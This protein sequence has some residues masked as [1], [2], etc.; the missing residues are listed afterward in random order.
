MVSPRPVTQ[1]QI[2]LQDCPITIPTQDLWWSSDSTDAPSAIPGP[3]VPHDASETNPVSGSVV[4][5][6]QDG[7]TCQMM[8]QQLQ[9]LIDSAVQ[10]SLAAGF[11][12]PSGSGSERLVASASP[13]RENPEDYCSAGAPASPTGSHRSHPS[14]LADMNSGEQGLSDQPAFTGLFPQ[15][16]F[17]SLLF[18]VVNI[19]Q[20]TSE[21]SPP[22]ST[23]APGSLD[24][25]FAEPAKPVM[26]IPTPPLFL[27]V[28][29]K[30]WVS[31]G[32][33]P[34]PSSNDR[35]N[36]TVAADSSSGSVC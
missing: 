33:A 30:Q 14:S 31:P 25:L 22:P 15:A 9:Y 1:D 5:P 28:I 34:S 18:K 32:S 29:K 20:F 17:P 27:N 19:A 6:P 23:P 8:P 4:K 7:V 21:A 12:P 24:P 2:S 16:L 13:E 35:K 11:W 10:R 3:V 36:F 26:A